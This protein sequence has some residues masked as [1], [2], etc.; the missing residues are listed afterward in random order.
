MVS[1]LATVYGVRAV[2]RPLLLAL[3][4]ALVLAAP[5]QAGGP[6]MLLGVA[7]DAV[8]RP[9]LV[10]ATANMGLLR[11]AGF[12]SVRITSIWVPGETEPTEEEAVLLENADA[13]AKLHGIRVFVSVYHF[14]SRTTPLTP[15]ARTEFASYAAAIAKEHESFRDFI[16]GNEPNLNRFWMPQFGPA[17]ENVSAPAYLELL[18]E[19][20]DALKQVSPETVVIGGSLAPRGID[21]PNTGRDTHSP[22]KFIRDLGA[23]YR[24][25][26]RTEPV[27][28]AFAHHPY[29]D[30]SRQ[31][32]SRSAHP[33]GTAIGLADYD[34]L[35]KLLGLAFDGTAQA[36]S[37]LPILYDEYGVESTIPAAKAGAYTGVEPATIRPVPEATQGAFY[38]EAIAMAFCHPNVFGMLLFHVLDE[39]D[40]DR[41]QSGV[42]YADGTPK[43][44]LRPVAT[45]VKHSRRGIVAR[46]GTLPLVPN[47]ALTQV[48]VLRYKL[49]C[50]IDCAW[51][52]WWHPVEEGGAPIRAGAGSARGGNSASLTL[53]RPPAGEY[54]LRVYL[55]APLN[56]WFPGLTVAGPHTF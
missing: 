22:S 16:V 39:P 47:G 10:A 23:A 12:D 51:S 55:T 53:K 40:L 5:A 54:G 3:L 7:D 44:S 49:A 1:S 9:D 50:D 33:S 37:T 36:G 46:C 42:L 34:K 6:G 27:M 21:R 19:T 31:A 18:A 43:A 2:G 11:L 14:G 24:A 4:V 25:S 32:P 56:P 48:S 29:G 8:K 28:D 17:G 35:V 30:S 41:W 52:A 26:G 20:Y 15:E 13:A 45:A 38:R